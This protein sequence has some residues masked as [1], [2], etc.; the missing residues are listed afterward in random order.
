MSFEFLTLDDVDVA[1]KHVLVRVDINSPIANDDTILDDTRIRAIKETLDDLETAKVVLLAHQS[2][3]G[4]KDFTSLQPHAEALKKIVGPRVK[5]CEDIF[6]YYAR[7]RI[8]KLKEGE[9]LLLENVRF[10]SEENIEAPPEELA[11]R[12]MIKKLAPLFDIFVNDAFPAAHRAHPSLVG[13]TEVLPSVAGRVMEKELK[14][15]NKSLNPARPCTFIVGGA[16]IE[17][18]LKI[19]KNILENGKADKILTGGLLSIVFLQAVGKEVGEVNKKNIDNFEIHVEEAKKL[20]EKYSDHI[21]IPTDVAVKK[22]NQRLEVPADKIPGDLQVLD[23]GLDSIVTYV[24]IILDS[25]TV[26]ANGPLGAFE[27]ANFA[28]G[29]KEILEAMGKCDGFTVIGGGELGAYA[30]V[31]GLN[32]KINHM[33]TGGGSMI[34]LLSG[35]KLPVIEALK[36][37]ALRYKEKMKKLRKIKK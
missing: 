24:K 7:E 5:F 15:L 10:Y 9:V 33:S 8:K 14:A 1:G 27:N 2:R 6:G 28:L 32:G 4:K 35:E 22:G 37:A 26:V 12:I 36:R 34:S 25:K 21:V 19:V 20:L 30:N 29:T 16:K 31:L 13:F 11:N 18:K 23:I 17:T 3:P